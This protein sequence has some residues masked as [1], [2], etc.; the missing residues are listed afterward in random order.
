MLCVA[1][2]IVTGVITGHNGQLI[3]IGLVIVAGL[4]GFL[5]RDAQLKKKLK[6]L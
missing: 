2:I 5:I 1:A 3:Q 4:G 6:Q